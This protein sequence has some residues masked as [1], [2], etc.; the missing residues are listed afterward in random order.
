MHCFKETG[1]DTGDLDD[2]LD[3]NENVHEGEGFQV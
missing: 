2:P 3:D 1:S